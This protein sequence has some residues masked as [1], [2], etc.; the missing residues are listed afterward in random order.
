MNNL[1]LIKKK[2]TKTQSEMID[3]IK[4][5]YWLL[6]GMVSGFIILLFAILNY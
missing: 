4:S 5:A 1:G 2:K 3:T 6:V